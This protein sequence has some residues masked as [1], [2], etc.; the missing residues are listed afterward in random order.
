M[1]ALR[2]D[3]FDGKLLVSGAMEDARSQVLLVDVAKDESVVLNQSGTWEAAFDD[4]GDLVIEWPHGDV[5][6]RED[7]C[8]GQASPIGSADGMGRWN[9]RLLTGTGLSERRP[10]GWL[11][12]AARPE[13]CCRLDADKSLLDVYDEE[14]IGRPIAHYTLHAFSLR[15]VVVATFEKRRVVA[16]LATEGR[17]YRESFPIEEASSASGPA[18][19]SVHSVASRTVP[20]PR[21]SFGPA[22]D[23]KA[24]LM[25]LDMD[26]HWLD[27]AT[28]K[29]RR[30]LHLPY[31]YAKVRESADGLVCLGP[32]WVDI[33]DISDGRQLRRIPLD[34]RYTI[35]LACLPDGENLLVAGWVIDR[36]SSTN[37]INAVLLCVNRKSGRATATEYVGGHLVVDAA[38]KTVLVRQC[39]DRNG[40]S[41]LHP[42]A[43]ASYRQAEFDPLVACYRIE[44][45]ALRACPGTAKCA[46]KEPALSADGKA[47]ILSSEGLGKAGEDRGTTILRDLLALNT[48][49]RPA[50]WTVAPAAST[51]AFHPS[52]PLVALASDGKLDLVNYSDRSN[53][54][55]R[56]DRAGVL[57]GSISSVLFNP[58]GTH[59]LVANSLFARRG[60]TRTPAGRALP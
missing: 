33:L 15:D 22:A 34:V 60:R 57:L 27:P 37:R 13:I 58:A 2:R 50:G 36:T 45:G 29:T 43:W 39:K 10:A 40:I 32:T 42:G 20:C 21:A 23:G 25:L 56:L 11:S 47:A 1:D 35:D 48:P 8:R 18:T 19:P 5:F 28:L 41:L 9:G 4:W 53:Q 6:T 7:F 17:V 59:L 49:E 16:G 52:L 3:R 46:W 55:E 12:D 31:P 26:L 51:G 24:F 38:G 14:D 30:K 54:S 44:S